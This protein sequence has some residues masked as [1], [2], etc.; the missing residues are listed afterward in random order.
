M[1]ICKIAKPVGVHLSREVH[2]LCNVI[3]RVLYSLIHKSTL[4]SQYTVC[5]SY[6]N[7]VASVGVFTE[8]C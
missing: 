1:P 7:K 2:V 6:G 3:S 4:H 5:V 8:N